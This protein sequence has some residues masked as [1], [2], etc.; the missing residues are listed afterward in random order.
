MRWTM[1]N[2]PCEALRTMQIRGQRRR[3]SR[4]SA[5]LWLGMVKPKGYDRLNPYLKSQYGGTSQGDDMR[6]RQKVISGQLDEMKSELSMCECL[7]LKG[8]KPSTSV[9]GARGEKMEGQINKTFHPELGCSGD[10]NPT[11]TVHLVNVGTSCIG[12]KTGLA[13]T[14]V[15]H[16]GRE[17]RS[18]LS[19][20]KPDTWR[21]TQASCEVLKENRE[22]RSR[23]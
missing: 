3:H 16:E 8:Y 6:C 4:W 22:V 14:K 13:A 18:S 11:V 9:E 20:G 19:Q 5:N 15:I 2:K 10:L 21:R 12:R 1:S 23:D 17:S 7:W